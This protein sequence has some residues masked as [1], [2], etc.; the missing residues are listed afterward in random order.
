VCIGKT[1]CLIGQKEPFGEFKNV[2]K[3][4]KS[5][6]TH[7]EGNILSFASAKSNL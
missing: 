4:E 5:L 2:S 7:G 3:Q 1:E 6:I